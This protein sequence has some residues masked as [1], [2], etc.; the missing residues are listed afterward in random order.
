M[1]KVKLHIKS[2]DISDER[3]KE[4]ANAP[5][6]KRPASK[7][8]LDVH[9]NRLLITITLYV[10]SVI[11]GF[12]VNKG[13]TD[14]LFDVLVMILAWVMILAGVIGIPV[15]VINFVLKIRDVRNVT[16]EAAISYF[17][18][19]VLMSDIMK[20]IYMK[21][22]TYSYKS[23][24]RMIPEMCTV[25]F[26]KFSE[27]IVNFRKKIREIVENEFKETFKT[28]T[29]PDNYESQLSPDPVNIKIET[30]EM[31]MTH[32][33]CGLNFYVEQRA[34]DSNESERLDYVRFDI[35]LD[36]LIIKSSEFRFLADPMLEFTFEDAEDKT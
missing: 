14:T 17:F 32:T 7:E 6:E 20:D 19:T 9:V 29:L 12:S 35:S 5:F 13:N 16:V 33:W 36:V 34:V 15:S 2:A 3:I 21:S 25:D 23:F 10:V 11:I 26:E 8:E 22:L 30:A 27:Y 1:K 18:N 28:S 24:M 4:L 31:C